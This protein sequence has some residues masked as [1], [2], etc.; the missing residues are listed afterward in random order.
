MTGI[1]LPTPISIAGGSFSVN[2]GAFTTCPTL[3]CT[4]R[5]GDSVRVRVAASGNFNTVSTA[6]LTIGG[7]SSTFQVLTGPSPAFVTPSQIDGGLHHTVVLKSDGTVWAWGADM[8]GQFNPVPTYTGLYGVAAVAAG[9]S[10]SFALR[11]DGSVWA[12]GD[13]SYGQLGDGTGTSHPD[14]RLIPNLSGVSAIAAGG[15]HTLALKGD[16][17]VLA[18]GANDFGELGNNSTVKSP[19]PVSVS[20]FNAVINPGDLRPVAIASGLEHSLALMSDGTVRAWGWNAFGQLGDGTTANKLVPTQVPGL[21]GV[22]IAIAAGANHS[23]ALKSDG[24]IWA[25]GY[26]AHGEL[27]NNSTVNSS[28][29]VQVLDANG[30]G[31]NAIIANSQIASIKIAA[32]SNHSFVLKSDGTVWAWGFNEH[33]QLGDGST[34]T[35]KVPVQVVGLNGVASVVGGGAGHSTAV[36]ADGTL[37]VWGWNAYQ[38]LGDGTNTDRL[39]PVEVVGREGDFFSVPKTAATPDPFHFVSRFGVAPNL[40]VTSNPIKVSGTSTASSVSISSVPPGVGAKYSVNNGPFSASLP[41]SVISGDEIRLQ[42]NAAASYATTTVVTLTIGGVSGNFHVVTQRDPA[43]VDVAHAVAA[44][45]HHTLVL[46]PNGMVWGFGYNG[47]GQLANGTTL[48]RSAPQQL[49]HLTNVVQ[50]AAGQYHTLALKG[51]RTLLASGWNGAGQLGDGTA[52]ASR[53][54]PVPVVGENGTGLLS[55]IVAIAAGHAHSLAADA[56][57]NVWAWGLNSDGQLGNGTFASS[58]RPLQVPGLTNVIAVAAG[59]RHSVA[60]TIDGTLWAW[61]NNDFGQLGNG[62]HESHSV[63]VQV[64]LGQIGKIAAGAAHTLALQSNGSL[65]AWGA[66]TF[67]QLG[68][69]DNTSLS[70]PT[71]VPE[72]EA[73]VTAIAAGQTHSMAVK[74]AQAGQLAGQL[75]VWGNNTNGQVGDGTTANRLT[76]FA[77]PNMSNIVAVAGGGRHTVALSA[78]NVLYAF[79]DNTFG[80]VG[81]RSGNYNPHGS[82]VN[83]L[84]G[85]VDIS[86]LSV[87]ASSAVGL[88]STTGT[89]ALNPGNWGPLVFPSQAV[90][91]ASALQ[92]VG[93]LNDSFDTNLPGVVFTASAPFAVA[94]HNCPNP[95]PPRASCQVQ[96]KFT[97]TQSGDQAGEFKATWHITDSNSQDVTMETNFP[98]QGTGTGVV[99]PAVSLAPSSLTFAG[100][101]VGTTSSAQTVTL[102]NTGNATLTISSI[103]ITGTNVSDF[104]QA[105]SCP[106]LAPSANC[107]V[108]VSFTPSAGGARS[109]SLTVTSNAANGPTNSVTLSGTGTTPLA[110]TVLTAGNGTGTI[111]SSPAGINCTPTCSASFASGSNVTLTA[112]PAA[113]SSL[114][115]WTGCDSVLGTTCTISSLAGPRSVTATFNQTVQRAFVS[116]TGNN[117]NTA[118]F[119][120]VTAPCKTFAA[121]VTVVADNGEVV[122][123]NT[124]PYGSVTLTRSISLTAAPGV[125]AGISVF[126]GSGVTIA[127]PGI[128]VVLRGLTINGQGGANGILVDTPATGA[129]YQ[130]RT[131]SSPTSRTRVVRVSP[132]T[133]PH[134]CAWSTHSY[135]TAS[136]E[137]RLRAAPPP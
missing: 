44:G 137:Y 118:T 63:P 69:G 123:L 38:T 2:G 45:N 93:F 94:S 8:A 32:G 3:D 52:G 11:P 133:Q 22:V 120:A 25:W 84:R 124:A 92:P 39:A 88:G 42:V 68:S 114:I 59:D 1:N 111:T 26:N 35:R 6:T 24:T 85:D 21:T 14:P 58:N 19:V 61:G 48:S 50:I 41:N 15:Y 117:A 74:V 129:K 125:Y 5:P 131:A 108:D 83:I 65:W 27:G 89:S 33:G 75:Y 135:A 62:T 31:F 37:R 9:L 126:A 122:A 98:L 91:T 23:L 77:V 12:W 105:S 99:A 17:T 130:L 28:V 121:A 96:L 81:N 109:A 79:G 43:A 29:P 40:L 51:D 116:A 95:I 71:L 55:N 101:N 10:A 73:R 119:C 127:S 90:T 134:N 80:Q 78:T 115:S 54:A 20:G 86:D 64:A 97:P 18:W 113:G 56:N 13:S 82:L 132:S 102:T 66:N 7:V 60:L 128:S 103:A 30:L 47:N 70:L 57:G 4:V 36:M 107:T 106:S 67:G 76:P 110:V 104:G 46:R 100:R 34:L 136:M 16:G 72:L 87:A 49:S 112:T 53:V